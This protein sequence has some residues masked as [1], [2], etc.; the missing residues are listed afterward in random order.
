MSVI[1]VNFFSSIFL[2]MLVCRSARMLPQVILEVGLVFLVLDVWAHWESWK[3]NI[4]KIPILNII[5]FFIG[6]CI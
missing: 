4:G 5:G 2:S 3:D 6:Y 1:L